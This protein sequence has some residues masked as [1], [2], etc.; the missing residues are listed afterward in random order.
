MRFWKLLPAAALASGALAAAPAVASA[1]SPPVI[2]P[3]C[4]PVPARQV[5]CLALVPT[6]IPEPF[7]VGVNPALTP[8]GYGPADLHHAYALPSGGSGEIVAVV[9]AYNDP[10]AQSN[11]NTYRSQYGLPATTL[12]IKGETG[13]APPGAAD[14]TGGWEVEESL[15]LDMVSAICPQ[16]HID[17]VEADTNYDTDLGTA[18]DEAD[19]LGAKYISNSYGGPEFSDEGLFDPPFDHPGVAVTASAGDSGYGAEWPAVNPDV[20]AVGGTT[21]TRGGGSRGW[22]ETVW[23]SPAGGEGTGSGCSAS[24]SKPSWQKDTGCSHRTDNDV[25][26]V[27]DPNT[28]VAVYDT[29]P[30]EGFGTGWIV[31]GGTSASSPVIAAT[32]AL[33]GTPPSAGFPAQYIYTQHT[34]SNVND[35]ST[36]ANGTCSP[37]YLCTGE[38]GYNGPTGWG[39]PEGTGALRAPGSAADGYISASQLW[40]LVLDDPSGHHGNG[41]L[42]QVYDALT[43]SHA[44]EQWD[45]ATHAGHDTVDLAG[46]S[47]CLD[48]RNGGTANGTQVQ[49]WACNGGVD[50][51]WLPLAGGELEAMNA[52]S[53]RH[54]PVVLDDPSGKGNGTKLQ[55]WQ[56]NGGNPQFWAVP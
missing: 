50:Q 6:G 13:G 32:Y 55:I 44:N 43:G 22:T 19:T 46:T 54:T 16:C 38:T 20:V 4:A 23:G 29:Y 15:D 36:G 3:A 56:M 18:V 34:A 53:A 41:T 35:V 9:D 39:T 12:T 25:A 7:K 11:L 26:A 2:K 37:A 52:T 30:N 51:Q 40:P 33:A 48:V 5:H 14:P 17:L 27:A 28:G 8:A 1:A 10:D 49:L 42:T 45:V 21:L 24:E 31:V 47:S